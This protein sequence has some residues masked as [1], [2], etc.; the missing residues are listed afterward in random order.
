MDVA[1]GA[2]PTTLWAVGLWGAELALLAMEESGAGFSNF[3]S[4]AAWSGAPLSGLRPVVVRSPHSGSLAEVVLSS[5]WNGSVRS[6][7]LRCRPLREG[8]A[9]W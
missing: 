1:R 7:T 5:T 8:P 2:E 4:G 9:R 6:S 3:W